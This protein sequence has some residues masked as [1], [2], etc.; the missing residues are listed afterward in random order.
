M[1]PTALSMNAVA[2]TNATLAAGILVFPARKSAAIMA[3]QS[4]HASWRGRERCSGPAGYGWAQMS[5]ESDEVG[6]LTR[7][8]RFPLADSHRQMSAGS[9]G[10]TNCTW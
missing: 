1:C 2:N 7:M 8:R 5:A 3:F 6:P 10:T 9:E 4:P